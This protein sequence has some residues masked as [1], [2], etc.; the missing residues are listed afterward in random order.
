MPAAARLIAF[1]VDG[2]WSPL[3]AGDRGRAGRAGDRPAGA[4]AGR[5]TRRPPG[6]TVT[7]SS[8]R[9][10][11]APAG[12]WTRVEA[13]APSP[14][15]PPAGFRR[16]WRLAPEFSPLGDDRLRRRP[17]PGE[18]APPR[19]RRCDP[20]TCS[21][22]PPSAG[23][24]LAGAGRLGRDAP[25]RGAA[26]RAAEP[27]RQGEEDKADRRRPRRRGGG[28]RGKRG[29]FLVVD[30][31]ALR[32]AGVDP[33]TAV[34]LKPESAED[35]AAP[36]DELGAA[37][38]CLRGGCLLTTRRQRAAWGEAAG[39][40]AAVES[41]AARRRAGAATPPAGSRPRSRGRSPP[42]RAKSP[43]PSPEMDLPQWTEWEPAPGGRGRGRRRDRSPSA[44]RGRGVGPRRSWPACCSW[45]RAGAGNGRGSGSCCSG[46]PRRGWAC[47][48]CRPRCGDWRGRPCSWDASPPSSGALA[49]ALR[50]PAQGRPSRDPPS[51]PPG[52]P[53]PCC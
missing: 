4:G 53:P 11:P 10:R 43:L 6:R 42:R 48:G 18:G 3:P 34:T 24:R 52:P 26:G 2:V 44:V 47:S 8:T 25:P 36:W 35:E 5:A 1:Q 27:P 9:P 7:R 29:E 28:L 12:P 19:R 50:R 20:K 30:A 41:A 46:W 31:A 37:A 22:R 17:G 33:S 16:L 40:P 45:G 39:R 23:P 15:V 38:V 21:G 49:S 14:P 13:P 32:D 51:P